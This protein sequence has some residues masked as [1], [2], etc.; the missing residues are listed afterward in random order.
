M[1]VLLEPK[2]FEKMNNGGGISK[3]MARITEFYSDFYEKYT[4]N[5]PL[6]TM[7]DAIAVALAAG[8]V[9][10]KVSPCVNVEVDITNGPGRGQTVCDL[11]GVYMNFPPQEGAHCYVPL[12]LEDGLPDYF[13]NLL[14]SAGDP[15]VDVS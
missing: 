5:K 11:R 8:L 12:E 14:A 3:Y 9:K 10:A 7:H 6:T 1:K 4:Y 2:H 15:A 13:T